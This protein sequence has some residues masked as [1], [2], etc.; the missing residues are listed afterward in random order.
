VRSGIPALKMIVLLNRLA[1]MVV[2]SRNFGNQ[3][4]EAEGNP[5]HNDSVKWILIDQRS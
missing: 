4:I 5:G 3:R 2:H 1:V